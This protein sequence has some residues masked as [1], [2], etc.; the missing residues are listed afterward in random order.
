M[1]YQFAVECVCD[2]LA[3]TKIYAGKEY[4]EN[5]PVEHW[6]RRGKNVR[7]NQRTLDFVERCLDDIRIHGEKHVMNKAYMKKTY[8]EICE[9]K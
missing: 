2:K 4:N 6:L 1:P 8:A 3:A 5:L 9:N 7:G